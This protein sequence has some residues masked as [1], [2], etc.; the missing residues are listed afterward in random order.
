MSIF[1][2]AFRIPQRVFQTPFSSLKMPMSKFADKE[3]YDIDIVE[4]HPRVAENC[5]MHFKHF[6]RFEEKHIVSAHTKESFKQAC[7]FVDSFYKRQTG[8]TGPRAVV[9]DSGCGTG[10]STEVLA[11]AYPTMPVIGI[12]RSLHRLSKRAGED[13]PSNALLVRADLVDFW[14]LAHATDELIVA[15][16]FL[17]YPNPYPKAKHLKRRFSGHPIFPLLVALGGELV[18]RSNWR[19][20][21]DELVTA[22]RSIETV[23]NELALARNQTHDD[24]DDDELAILSASACVHPYTIPPTSAPMTSFERKY[25]AVGVPLFELR[26]HLAS[27]AR[28]ERVTLLERLARAVPGSALWKQI[29][30]EKNVE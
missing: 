16:H 4:E 2:T 12:D 29:C 30:D 8:H 15:K 25:D 22:L 6:H 27:R 23:A 17:L 11:Y 7:D 18:V 14:T 19:V 10:M 21:L 9:L 20:Y 5:L 24:A 3:I 26:V 28:S 13:V 1:G